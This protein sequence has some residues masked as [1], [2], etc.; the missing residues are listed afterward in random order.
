MIDARH[1]DAMSYFFAR[2]RIRVSELRNDVSCWQYVAYKVSLR[3]D[4]GVPLSLVW[5]LI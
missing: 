3:V 1:L 5:F 2:V 4:I